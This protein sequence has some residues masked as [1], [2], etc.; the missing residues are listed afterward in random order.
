MYTSRLNPHGNSYCKTSRSLQVS[1]AGAGVE[2]TTYGLW[3]LRALIIMPVEALASLH[4]GHAAGM[5]ADFDARP[6][7]HPECANRAQRVGSGNLLAGS[8]LVLVARHPE[9]AQYKPADLPLVESREG[10]ARR[11]DGPLARH[12]L[13]PCENA[14]AAQPPHMPLGSRQR[15]PEGGLRPRTSRD[16]ARLQPR[17]PSLRARCRGSTS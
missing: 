2:P 10:I 17:R 12:H 11:A 9:V 3:E 8:A 7:R 1:G 14:P 15:K 6:R 16:R 5:P 4:L 13:A